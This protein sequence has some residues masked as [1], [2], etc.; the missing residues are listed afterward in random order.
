[1]LNALKKKHSF[2][3]KMIQRRKKIVK[4]IMIL[5]LKIFKNALNIINIV[6]SAYSPSSL[7]AS[8]RRILFSFW[9]RVEV[10]WQRVIEKEFRKERRIQ[11]AKMV[12]INNRKELCFLSNSFFTINIFCF[13]RIG[14]P[15]F[16]SLQK[17]HA[18]IIII[19]LFFFF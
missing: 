8:T 4:L 19:L 18:D 16:N 2:N 17:F 3:N 10:L 14:F 11:V 9:S 13:F 15:H 7:H 12:L 5:F 1:M 6:T